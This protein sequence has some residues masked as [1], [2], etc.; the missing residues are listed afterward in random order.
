MD[1]NVCYHL[2]RL[3][4]ILSQ[5]FSQRSPHESS[6][7]FSKISFKICFKQFSAQLFLQRLF[8][9]VRI[10]PKVFATIFTMISNSSRFPQCFFIMIYMG[11]HIVPMWMS[12]PTQFGFS[13]FMIHSKFS[14]M[15]DSIKI[16]IIVFSSVH[17]CVSA[18]RFL[19]IYDHVRIPECNLL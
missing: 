9:F 14:R 12:H 1:S 11:L 5:Q 19:M 8:Q 3:F 18:V 15:F 7:G 13:W 16:Y 6:H 10:H 4:P 17:F 2:Y